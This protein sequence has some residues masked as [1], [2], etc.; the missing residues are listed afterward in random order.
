[1]VGARLDAGGDRAV[2]F[3]LMNKKKRARKTV[4]GAT[5]ADKTFN[6]AVI[7]LPVIRACCYMLIFHYYVLAN[8]TS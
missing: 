3:P 6:Y 2:A 5:V 8:V 7:L 1:V 4:D